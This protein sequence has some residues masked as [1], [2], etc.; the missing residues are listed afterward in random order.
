MKDSVDLELT[1]GEKF[2]FIQLPLRTVD[3]HQDA[4]GPEN[5]QRAEIRLKNGACG[6]C[7][8]AD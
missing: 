6:M 1:L 8:D 7:L 3:F 2:V 5:L 4:I